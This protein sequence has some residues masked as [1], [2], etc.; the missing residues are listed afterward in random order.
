MNKLIIEVRVNENAMRFHNRHVPWLAREIAADAARCAAAGASLIHYHART[1]EGAAD[2]SGETYNDIAA[3]I[4]AR[5]DLLLVPSLANRPGATDADRIANLLAGVGRKE[6]KP[7][8]LA[9]EPGSTNMTAFDPVA[10]T[11]VN[12][13]SVYVNTFDSVDFML[14]QA[15]EYGFQP[16]L[17]SFNVSWSRAVTALFD[18]KRVAS[19]ALLLLVHGGPSFIA[20]HPAT[21][22]G[23]DA[24]LRFLPRG[25]DVEWSV[26]C[27]GA[28]AL[29][30]AAVAIE[31]GGHVA[32]GLGDH[33]YNELGE[34]TNA[35]LVETVVTLARNV[36]REVARPDEVRQM[37]DMKRR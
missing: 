37:L 30:L 32:L 15:H 25:H 17:T 23:L 35:E 22:E 33:P 28:N 26:C 7:D 2:H 29:A 20:A 18:T 8:F 34:P 21:L 36:G 24:H 11:L 1:E 16:Y 19:P 12:T 4:R 6:T 5:C 9:V 14:A 13:G 10:R 3:E 27:H 31:R